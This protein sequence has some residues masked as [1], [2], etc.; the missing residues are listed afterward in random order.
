MSA[1]S[2]LLKVAIPLGAA[3]VVGRAS[4]YDVPGGYRAVM[5]DRFSGVQD[6]ATSEGTHFLIP[7]LQRAILYDCRIKPRNISTTTGSKDLQM[8]SIT[9]RVLSRPDVSHLPKIYQSLGMDYDERVLPSIGNEVLKSI[10]AQF[11]AAE[12]ITQREVVSSRIRADLLH[13]AGEFNIKLEDVSITHLTF[14]KEFTQAVEAKQIAQQDAER[15]KFIV[16][17][18]EQERQAAVIRAEGEAEAAATISKALERAGEAF[19]AFRKIEAAK[20]IVQSLSSNPGI[21]YVPASSGNLLLQHLISLPISSPNMNMMS[22][23]EAPRR[24]HLYV[25]NLS[26]RVTEYMLT[27]IFA[28]AGPVQHVKIIP[29]RNYQHGGLNYGFVEYMDMRA[30]ETALQTLNGRK[31]FDTEIRVN[32]AYQGQQNKEDTTGHY[33]VFVGDLS[34]E[35]NDEVLGKAFSAF[36]TMSDARVMWDMNSGKSRGYGFLAFRDKTDAEQAIATMNGE[37]LGSRAIR[38]NWANQ[39]TQG[40]GTT[41]SPM[42]PM[43]AA[44][45]ARPA[46][47]GMASP[48]GMGGGAPAAAPMNF[49]G[50]PM[51]YE[52]TLSQTPAYN[53]TVYVGNLVPYCT[54]ADLIPLF[55]SIGYLSE[56]RMQADR[57]FA[58]VKLD[59]H[60]HAAQ[61]IVQLQ[62]QNVHGR[63]IKCSWGKDRNDGTGGQP[64]SPATNANPYGNLPMYGMPQAAS[65][66]QYGFGAYP[67]F[68]QAGGAG[69]PGSP[70]MPQPAGAA[71]LGLGA[72]AGQPSTDPNA[73]AGQAGQA[74]WGADP[75]SYYSN[76]WG[77]YYGQ[78]QGAEAQMQGP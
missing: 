14:G 25:G 32:W 35:V 4:I 59:T 56:I 19:V 17:K 24:A 18:A 13:R 44:A 23:A 26:P 40:G 6:K 72:G 78:Q 62:G 64:M 1:Q 48:M 55:Q 71:G 63:P 65:Y 70:G 3:L 11:D 39:K 20:A 60:E 74:Q 15:A 54:Q 29:D 45:P 27:E 8:V 7:W 67:G 34:P 43:P 16:E 10:V 66:G 53:S 47:T 28:V 76:Y 38:V 50:G 41:G 9:L 22:V 51:S 49:Q 75:N 69:V 31:I 52:A 73:L 46:G 36:G 12:L 5:F 30:A 2:A 42:P 37:W 57:G 33:H 61:A 77:G 68:N 21:S 58:F